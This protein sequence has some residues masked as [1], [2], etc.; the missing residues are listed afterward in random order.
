VISSPTPTAQPGH[1]GSANPR[2]S[3]SVLRAIH[4]QGLSLEEVAFS[5][6]LDLP[7][8]RHDGAQIYLLLEGRYVES[9]AGHEHLLTP[10]IC[11]FRGASVVHR[12]SVPGSEPAL[13]LMV[14]ADVDR[15]SWLRDRRRVSGRIP[16]L[17]IEEVRAEML[18]EL[19]IGDDV[20]RAALEGWSLLLLSVAERA[21]VGQLDCRARELVDEASLLIERRFSEPVSLAS[22]AAELAV[23]P[24]TLAAAFRRFCNTS[25]GERLRS[26]RLHHA[27][28]ALVSG[29][30]PIKQI[31]AECG[32]FDQAHLG[33]WC[34]RAF[35][36]SP[37]QIR[38]SARS[39]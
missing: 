3:G 27:R 39:V 30:A 11:W 25:V 31:A 20:S 26:V 23:H 10:G 29:R 34:K 21:R 35:G 9:T 38:K 22:I 18:R 28:R 7:D 24:L 16:S 32:F 5:P 37:A 2:T 12:N 17:V 15:L 13:C 36:Q 6:G 4:W 33:R 14:T 8:H 1:H 19:R